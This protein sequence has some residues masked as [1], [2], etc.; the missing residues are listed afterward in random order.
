[1]VIIARV[2]SVKARAL[3]PRARTNFGTALT[4]FCHRSGTP[5]TPVEHTMIWVGRS[6]PNSLAT[7]SVVA[8]AAVN[9]SDPVQ[10]LAFPEFTITPR[11]SVRDFFKWSCEVMTGAA[12]TR[13]VVK[14]AAAVAGVSLTISP[15]S[16]PDFLRPHATEEYAK[17]RGT[18]AFEKRREASDSVGNFSFRDFM[19]S[20]RAN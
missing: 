11:I 12:F 5:I 6:F 8:V 18:S 7:L 10:Q 2:N 15:K 4:I 13:L 20:L 3:W 19:N 16:N 9:P 1:V 14:T 17:P